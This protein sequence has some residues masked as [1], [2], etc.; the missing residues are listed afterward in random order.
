MFSH[1]LPHT[2][3]PVLAN[4]QKFIFISSVWILDAIKKIYQEQWPVGMDDKKELRESMLSVYH[5]DD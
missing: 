1:G 2:D 4:K 3:T 5:D